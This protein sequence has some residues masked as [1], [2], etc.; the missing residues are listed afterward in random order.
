MSLTNSTR[1]PGQDPMSL[2]S[3]RIEQ[4]INQFPPSE[5]APEI[6]WGAQYD[7]GLAW[8]NFPVGLGG[9]GVSPALS[10]YVSTALRA[11]GAVSNFL[12]NPIGVGMGGPTL[13]THGSRELA[14]Q[15]LRPMFTCQDI[16]CQLFSEPNAGSDVAS[17]AAK[18]ERDGD[19]WILNGQKVWTTLAHVAHWGMIVTRTDPSVPKHA[20]MTYFV[21]DMRSP[22]VEVRPLR[23]MTG[24]A[25]FNEVYFNNVRIPD[26]QRLGDVGKGWNVAIT[27]LMNERVS[28]GGNTSARGS[29][30]IAEAIRIWIA[31]GVKSPVH[32]DQLLSLW[33]AAEVN[34][35]TN[36]RAAQMRKAGNPGPEGSVA[37]LGYA[38]LNQK[39]YSFCINLLGAQGLEYTSYEMS[40]P[41]MARVGIDKETKDVAKMFLRSRANSIE[42]GTSEIMRNIL[43]ERVLGLPGEPRADKDLPWNETP[44]N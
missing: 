35:L 12:R 40:S 34:R 17:L 29:G 20:G 39:I 4:L 3:E 15:L 33:V 10:E 18:A 44:K 13:V 42:G 6:F 32:R 37:K 22:G 8:V 28:I 26:S 9:L 24:E 36:I 25:E 16:W 43:G 31:S 11:A 14:S 2:V 1:G 19:E 23:Q 41:E 38:E 27:T 30:A 5:T 7:L 21:V